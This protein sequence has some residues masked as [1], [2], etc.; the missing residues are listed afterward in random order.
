MVRELGGSRATQIAGALAVAS[1]P[2]AL[3]NGSILTYV[4]FDYLWWVL[5]A[6]LLIRRLKSEDPRWWLAIGA[7]IGLGMMTKYTMAF[8]AAALAGAVLVTRS[9]RDL[10]SPWLWGGVALS[11][12]I[13]LPNLLW[14]IRHDFISLDFLG[15]IHARDVADGRTDLFLLEQLLLGN[16]PF[17]LAMT[18]AGVY[19][20]L[21]HADGARYRLLGWLY[22]LVFV[23]FLVM[24]G[25]G[26]YLGAAYPMLTAGGAILWERWIA[27][28]AQF[29]RRLALGG[30]YA[31]IILGAGLA[32][33]LFLPLTPVN[34]PVWKAGDATFELFREQLGWEELVQAVAG[35]YNDLPAEER[36]LTGIYAGNYGEAGALNMY[37]PAY[38]LPE[39]ISGINTYWLR[40]YGD[41]P[42]QTLILVGESLEGA[43]TYFESCELAAGPITN[44][45]GVENE[46][47]SSYPG[48]LLCRGLKQPWSEIWPEIL[49]FG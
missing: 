13:F 29:K 45:Y 20:F 9:R 15:S 12:L 37:G 25:R 1:S 4:C 22:V 40:G 42:P 30:T 34:S 17:L 5:I 48:V 2:I 43:G 28:L 23:L 21:A 18:A 19:F 3:N 41:P 33:L 16:N 11:I 38:G 46:E 14:Q 49:H 8:Y 31:A 24:R 7:V 44:R 6:Y 36:A 10:L 47:S 32:A 39:A 26:Y 35:V 27:S